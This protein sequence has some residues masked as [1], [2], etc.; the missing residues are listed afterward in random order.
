M[1]EKLGKI[2]FEPV[3]WVDTSK[4]DPMTGRPWPHMKYTKITLEELKELYPADC[5]RLKCYC[6]I[7]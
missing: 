2:E 5:E 4:I 6:Q 1:D 3:P 7:K